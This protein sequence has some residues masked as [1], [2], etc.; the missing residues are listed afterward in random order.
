MVRHCEQSVPP[1][2]AGHVL[3]VAPD[4]LLRHV[5]VQPVLRALDV[6]EV[7]WLLQWVAAE[8]AAHT[9]PDLK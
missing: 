4:H 2:G 7:A 5:H 9:V 8:H 1:Y 6:T 3:H